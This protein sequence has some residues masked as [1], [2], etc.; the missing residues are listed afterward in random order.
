[1]AVFMDGGGIVS[2]AR[3]FFIVCISSCY[4]GMFQGTGFLDG[5]QDGF[6]KL[7]KKI[8]PFG[9]ILTASVLSSAVSCNQTLAIMLTHQLCGQIEMSPKERAV[10]LENSAVVIAPLIPWSIAGAVPLASVGAPL[11]SIALA[12]YLYLIPIWYF[13]AGRRSGR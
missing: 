1:M 9:A 8:T 11:S 7:G 13:F 6:Q 10:S 5:M 12:F 3:V 4:S 2:M